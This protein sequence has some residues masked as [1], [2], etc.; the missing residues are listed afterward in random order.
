MHAFADQMLPGPDLGWYLRNAGRV[1]TLIIAESASTIAQAVGGPLERL[2]E[3][4]INRGLRYLAAPITWRPGARHGVPKGLVA[5]SQLVGQR[6]AREYT[7]QLGEALGNTSADAVLQSMASIQRMNQAERTAWSLVYSVAGLT[8]GQSVS[9]LAVANNRL[10]RYI[11]TRKPVGPLDVAR[12]VSKL[13]LSQRS[14]RILDNESEVAQNFGTQLALLNAVKQGWLPSGTRKVWV[15][16]V[17]ER[18]CPVCKP[19]DSVAVALDEPFH[20]RGHKGVLSRDLKLW[21]PPA[22]PNC[23]CRIVPERV[24]EHGII[25]RT[26]R[27]ARD[28][29]GRAR[30]KSRLDDLVSDAGP[31]WT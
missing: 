6:W 14:R 25:T 2:V 21:V 8:P 20:V 30:A 16:A 4:G 3:F 1:R 5:N 23:R 7:R 24:I 11:S 13:A 19:M 28:E 27:F 22:H 9:V 31:E 15:T 26:A 29:Q 12:D 10:A 17:D 18:V